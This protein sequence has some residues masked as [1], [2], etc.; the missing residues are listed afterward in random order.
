M[1]IAR[2]ARQAKRLGPVAETVIP[3][4]NQS[5]R[6]DTEVELI[7]YYRDFIRLAK[8]IPKLKY[9][10]IYKNYIKKHVQSKTAFIERRSRILS[11]YDDVKPLN[12]SDVLKRIPKTIA[13]VQRGLILKKNELHSTI[14]QNLLKFEESKL[15]YLM[16]KRSADKLIDYRFDRHEYHLEGKIDPKDELAGLREMERTVMRLNE[17]D[18]MCL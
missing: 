1:S 18:E 2:A 3:I 5:R 9:Q 10:I 11:N 8:F 12:S 7:G 14:L 13:F 6:P 16:R 17:S 15:Q 4:V